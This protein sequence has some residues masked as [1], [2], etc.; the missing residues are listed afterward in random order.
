MRTHRLPFIT[1]YL[2]AKLCQE[3][4]VLQDECE[5]RKKDLK[6]QV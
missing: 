5:N 2:F 1:I 3:H 6:Q 4:I